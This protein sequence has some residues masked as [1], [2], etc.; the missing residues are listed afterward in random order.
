LRLGRDFIGIEISEKYVYD[1]ANWHI[2][3]AM[4][5]VPVK[6]QRKGQGALFK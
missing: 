6:E 1:I 2:Q 4:T 3:A 5:G